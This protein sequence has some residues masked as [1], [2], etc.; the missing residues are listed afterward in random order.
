[1][2]RNKS[3]GDYLVFYH[4]FQG[5]PVFIRNLDIGG[6]ETRFCMRNGSD[7]DNILMRCI[8]ERNLANL[9]EQDKFAVGEVKASSEIPGPVAM[10]NDPKSSKMYILVDGDVSIRGANKSSP[11]HVI[12][13]YNPGL[14]IPAMFRA[15]KHVPKTAP[16]VLYCQCQY[17][18][19]LK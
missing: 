11:G 1:M 4:L 5:D 6:K 14:I 10:V 2:S 7:A 9:L 18:K 17:A 12:I 8:R 15:W 16:L 3:Y 13:S 19:E